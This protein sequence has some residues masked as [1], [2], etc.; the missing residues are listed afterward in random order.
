M[1][2]QIAPA[3]KVQV[4]L[5]AP[6]DSDFH[7]ICD[8]EMGKGLLSPKSN[9]IDRGDCFTPTKLPTTR[10]TGPNMRCQCPPFNC[11]LLLHLSNDACLP[12]DVL[13]SIRSLKIEFQVKQ[14]PGRYAMEWTKILTFCVTFLG[15]AKAQSPAFEGL[16]PAQ[17]AAYELSGIDLYMDALLQFAV[18]CITIAL[19]LPIFKLDVVQHFVTSIF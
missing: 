16:L 2:A 17:I 7:Q 8:W 14:L 11:F 6:R 10:R 4:T 15:L 9:Q 18:W 1:S 3:P 13:N 5:P 12:G 19:A